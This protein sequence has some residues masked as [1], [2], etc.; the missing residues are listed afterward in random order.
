MILNSNFKFQ[1]SNWRRGFTLIELIVVIA[2]IAVLSGVILFS[3]T[4]YI[5]KG[6]D[7]NISGNLAILITAGEAYYNISNNYGD[8]CNPTISAGSTFKNIISQMPDQIEGAPCYASIYE[9][10]INPKG[11]CCNVESSRYQAWSAC[12]RKFSDPNFAICVDSRGI[13][14][15]ICIESCPLSTSVC[16]NDDITACP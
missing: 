7:S 1:I 13:K 15:D 3:V 8:F 14:K 12:A 9:S 2:I 11:V 6:K 16:P 4:H 10:T 5:A